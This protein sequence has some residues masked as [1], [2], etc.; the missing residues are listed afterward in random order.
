MRTPTCPHRSG[1]H[2]ITKLALRARHLAHM[3]SA[4][5]LLRHVGARSVVEARKEPDGL[6]PRL[7]RGSPGTAKALGNSQSIS[8]NARNAA[9]GPRSPEAGRCEPSG[10]ERP[11]NHGLRLQPAPFQPA[12]GTPGFLSASSIKGGPNVERGLRMRAAMP[13]HEQ[14]ESVRTPPPACRAKALSI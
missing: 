2:R 11:G 12:N 14:I 3:P 13:A 9:G 5:A 7:M 1:R 4:H 10:I 6:A 8:E